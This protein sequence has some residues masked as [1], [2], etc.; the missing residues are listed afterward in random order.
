MAG[1]AVLSRGS[2]AE[3]ENT[4]ADCSLAYLQQLTEA[5][6]AALQYS[7]EEAATIDEVCGLGCSESHKCRDAA[8]DDRSCCER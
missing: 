6:L 3:A 1:R 4:R 2:D 7:A 5:A 8:T